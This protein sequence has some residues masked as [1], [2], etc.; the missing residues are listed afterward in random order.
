MKHVTL[1]AAALT[2]AGAGLASRPALAEGPPVLNVEK[3]CKSAASASVG[4]SDN[5]SQ[6]GCLRSERDAKREAERHWDTY[7]PA[8]KAQCSKQFEAGGYPSYVEMVTCLELA[9]GTV[10]TQ[11]SGG[12]VATGGKGS[13][14]QATGSS[15]APG[16]LTR[17][18][19]ASQRTDPQKVLDNK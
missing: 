12:G 17:E 9:S 19:P 10:P 18:P 11:P 15:E 14:K 1:V 16:N 6:D 7:T 13:P 3:T 8:A 5:A 4:I 2:L